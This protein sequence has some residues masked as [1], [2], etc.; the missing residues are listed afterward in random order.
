MST[1]Q[2]RIELVRPEG[3]PSLHILRPAG[4]IN[5]R[6][7]A[8]FEGAL[9]D[10]REAG[11]VDVILDMQSCDYLN[12]TGLAT[13]INMHQSFAALERE[14]VLAQVPRHVAVVIS[15]MG[16]SEVLP[17]LKDEAEARNY[18]ERHEDGNRK[19]SDWTQ[20]VQ[21]TQ[22]AA[23]PRKVPTRRA[24][25]QTGTYK[26]LVVE[27]EACELEEVLRLRLH[28]PQGEF[29]V[30]R[31]HREAADLFRKLSPEVVVLRDTGDDIDDLIEKLKIDLD[32]PLVS[33]LRM[34]RRGTELD[35][36]VEFK[37]WENDFVIEPFNVMELF[38]LVENEIRRVR[39]DRNGSRHQI[40]FRFLS[41]E[42]MGERATA[43][44]ERVLR[45]SPLGEEAATRLLSA[46]NE[47]V[48]NARRHG[49][50]GD[51]SKII[52]VVITLDAAIIG[53]QITDE[54]PGFNSDQ[55]T[56]DLK[57][58]TAVKRAQKARSMGRQ[59][60]LGILLMFKCC[61]RVSYHGRGNILL[62]E[63]DIDE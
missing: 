57:D 12:S 20:F 6:T 22:D 53:V 16:L 2:L 56:K 7:N 5:A 40:N 32:R 13:L 43:F 23:G 49:N 29:H 4:F 54:G 19:F 33:V 60:G 46:F 14:I 35:G 31:D 9:E 8:D 52:D 36:K 47:A 62:L 44:A 38:T 55:W 41:T 17:I 18:L 11:D 39:S 24:P 30:A 27:P 34:Y 51:T 25:T 42:A 63:Q 58:A 45:S 61:S 59:G 48:D 26:V 37:I 21:S 15:Q 10:S 3:E 28:D 1:R 50:G